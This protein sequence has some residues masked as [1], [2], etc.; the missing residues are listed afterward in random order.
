MVILS[1]AVHMDA[2]SGL[3]EDDLVF[4]LRK[5]AEI[6]RS[7][8][9]PEP[10]RIAEICEQAADEIDA[11]RARA[12]EMGE[13]PETAQS[14]KS[15]GLCMYC[16]KDFQLS[17]YGD[18]TAAVYEA[19]IAHDAVC[20]K[21]PLAQ[22]LDRINRVGNTKTVDNWLALSEADKRKWF[23]TTLRVD[24]LKA[25]VI[26]DLEYKLELAESRLRA[27][28]G[29]AEIVTAA[30]EVAEAVRRTEDHPQWFPAL[31][32]LLDAIDAARGR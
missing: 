1:L 16:G 9:R 8:P 31:G 6:R 26:R 15:A 24:K 20:Q 3:P 12:R 13:Q 19:V 4:R 29:D 23:A 28:E 25:N 30:K 27:A 10:D 18:S 5:R 32:K 2:L 17:E 7:I 11:L 22:E 14:Q 21:N